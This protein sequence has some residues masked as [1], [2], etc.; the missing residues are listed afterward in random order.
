MK[1]RHSN[2]LVTRAIGTYR[3][4][5]GA[6]QRVEFEDISLGGCRVEDLASQLGLGEYVELTIGEAGPFI[7]EVAWRQTTRVGLEFSQPLPKRV[8]AR[9]GEGFDEATFDAEL[10]AREA[11]PPRRRFI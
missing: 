5:R 10:K 11:R 3:T 7:A 4:S 1:E 9:L 8:L 6:V 2:R